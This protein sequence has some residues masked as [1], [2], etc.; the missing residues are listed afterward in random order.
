MNVGDFRPLDLQ[1]ARRRE[2]QC[3]DQYRG[4]AGFILRAAI[5][6]YE[7]LD[8]ALIR[9]L[10]FDEKIRVDLPDEAAR[11]QILCRATVATVLVAVRAQSLCQ[12]HARMERRETHGPGE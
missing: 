3:L 4:A 10:R 12:P 9:D 2:M 6:F 1:M 5:N 8:E 11:A 7:G